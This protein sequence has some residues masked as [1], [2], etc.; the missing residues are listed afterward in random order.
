MRIR[1]KINYTRYLPWSLGITGLA[2][3]LARDAH[4]IGVITL[5]YAAT[6]LNH[7]MLLYI[8]SDILRDP[9]NA[10]GRTTNKLLLFIFFIAKVGVIVGA[11]AFGW[12]FMGNRII[13]PV[14]NYVF[15][16]FVLGVSIRQNPLKS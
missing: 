10:E 9:E 12:Q 5:V 16:I 7:Y 3:L 15:Q 14:L 1:E 8:V 13:I 6:L 4:D 11:C 2:L